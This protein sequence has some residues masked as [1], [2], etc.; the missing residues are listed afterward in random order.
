VVA[1]SLCPASCAI[2]SIASSPAGSSGRGAI[3]LGKTVLIMKDGHMVI[4]KL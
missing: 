2:W 1:V 4:N 3:H